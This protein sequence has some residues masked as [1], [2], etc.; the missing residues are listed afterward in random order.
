MTVPGV[1]TFLIKRHARRPYLRLLV[2][3]ANGAPV[4]FT[5]AVAVKF[6]MYGE[7]GEKINTT[8]TIES[9][10]TSGVLAYEW[11][12]GDTDT[13][14]EFQGEFDVDYGSGEHL[15]VPLDGMLTIRIFPDLDDA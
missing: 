7:A 2:K 5:S 15:T 13:E 1:V 11:A 10:A 9:P 3:D 14:G 12:A 4:D 6:I 8:G